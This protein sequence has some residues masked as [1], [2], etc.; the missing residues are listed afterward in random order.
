MDGNLLECTRSPDLTFTHDTS[1]CPAWL[2]AERA[3]DGVAGVGRFTGDDRTTSE[4]RRVAKWSS[5][6]TF[7]AETRTGTRPLA[8]DLLGKRFRQPGDIE[9]LEVCDCCFGVAS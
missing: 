5:K 9:I 2:H 8:K 1:G 7:A 6:T 4:I 3:H